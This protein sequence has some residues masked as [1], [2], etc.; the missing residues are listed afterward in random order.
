M[1]KNINIILLTCASLFLSKVHAKGFLELRQSELVNENAN[2]DSF[3]SYAELL[4][5]E[6]QSFLGDFTY[7]HDLSFRKYNNEN[8]PLIAISEVYVSYKMSENIS[9]TLGRKRLNWNEASQFWAMGEIYSAKG[10]NGIND[11]EEGTTG[12]HLN[13]SNKYFYS[14]FVISAISIPS[15]NPG[16]NISDGTIT[17]KSEWSAPPPTDV[18][19]EGQDIPIEYNV[20]MPPISDLLVKESVALRLGF[21]SLLGDISLFGGRKPEPSARIN[22]TGFLDQSGE[23]KAVVTARPFVN[24]QNF[25]GASWSKN[26]NKNFTTAANY[27]YI[28]PEHGRDSSFEFAGFK[29]EPVYNNI[30]YG[31][32]LARWTSDFFSLAV[33]GLQAFKRYDAT[34][35]TFAKRLRFEKAYGV[36]LDWQ[37][38]DSLYSGIRYQVDVRN[39]DTLV[40]SYAKLRFSRKAEVG[41]R[42]Q[43]VDS[44]TDNSYWSRF[45]ENDLW[46]VWFGYHF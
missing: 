20:D 32:F 41:F 16:L 33:H 11:E 7:S 3:T 4:L 37:L 21:R 39:E 36:N 28:N 1:R 43:Q 5:K 22:A 30:S 2:I 17:A 42:Y 14:D 35:A 31:S 27:E 15:L 13:Y 40:S 46:Q 34:D 12:L 45:R 18:R 19:F 8:S 25:M 9:T 6:K 10:F 44:E 38:T 23:S 29:I 24:M 26:W